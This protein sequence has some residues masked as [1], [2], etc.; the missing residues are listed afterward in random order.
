MRFIEHLMLS[1]TNK[2]DK[3]LDPF[4][5]VGNTVIAALMHGNDA[6]GSET[7]KDHVDLAKDRI[8]KRCS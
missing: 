8:K 3:V 6:I 1:P 2:G 7:K 4:I 5:D